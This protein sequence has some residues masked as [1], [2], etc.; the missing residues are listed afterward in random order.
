MRK[1]E[2]RS[3]NFRLASQFMISLLILALLLTAGCSNRLENTG[4]PAQPDKQDVITVT[5]CGA[6]STSS[7]SNRARG[8]FVS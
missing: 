2:D 7:G 3:S 1:I 6:A 4:T 8:L 5:D